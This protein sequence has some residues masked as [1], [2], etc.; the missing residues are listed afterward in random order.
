VEHHRNLARA[1]VP[2]G[3]CVARNALADTVR[4]R[5]R[6]AFGANPYPTFANAKAQ[7]IG[8]SMI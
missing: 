2:E 1:E 5:A 7:A 4:A 6:G 8:A 3:R